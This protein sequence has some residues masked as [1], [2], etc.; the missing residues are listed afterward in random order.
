M[1]RYWLNTLPRSVGAE[2]LLAG[3]R[4]QSTKHSLPGPL[5]SLGEIT[6]IYRR[7]RLNSLYQT[8]RSP[9]EWWRMRAE[10]GLDG[11]GANESSGMGLSQ[12]N[13][14][15][16]LGRGGDSGYGQ[17]RGSRVR[18][19]KRKESSD[20]GKWGW[21]GWREGTKGGRGERKCNSEM[22]QERA[23]GPP[24]GMFLVCFT[25]PRPAKP[26]AL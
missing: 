4:C 18:E 25:T 13:G 5:G 3:P 8:N 2:K 12:R 11:K 21:S 19:C 14:G 26:F 10:G 24:W 23:P 20:G 17:I 16:H 15:R 7:Q 22:C 9:A 1:H 6:G